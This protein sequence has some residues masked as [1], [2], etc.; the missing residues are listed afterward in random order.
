MK[1]KDVKG[2]RENEH[3]KET[4]GEQEDE[5]KEKVIV[6]VEYEKEDPEDKE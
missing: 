3:K 1:D 6:R 4:R 2:G 5:Y